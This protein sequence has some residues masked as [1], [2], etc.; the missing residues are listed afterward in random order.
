MNV[1]TILPA[2]SF[3]REW[4]KNE[5]LKNAAM[6]IGKRRNDKQNDHF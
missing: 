2:N 5:R 1:I 6:A 4:V 3:S